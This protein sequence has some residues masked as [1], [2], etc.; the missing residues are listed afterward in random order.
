MFPVFPVPFPV[1]SQSLANGLI[2]F[3]AFSVSAARAVSA[4]SPIAFSSV[5]EHWEQWELD[6]R[7]RT[8]AKSPVEPTWNDWEQVKR[9]LIRLLSCL[10]SLQ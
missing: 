3:P 8:C 10:L 9:Q 5:G 7:R 6:G 2:V 4:I 1:C